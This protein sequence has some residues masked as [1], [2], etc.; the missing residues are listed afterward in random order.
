METQKGH[1][2]EPVLEGG[3]DGRKSQERIRGAKNEEVWMGVEGRNLKVMR[4]VSQIEVGP[5]GS[6]KDRRRFA[7]SGF[8]GVV[9]TG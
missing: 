2:Q 8:T 5:G 9:E 7:K 4:R 3:V 6:R 1:G